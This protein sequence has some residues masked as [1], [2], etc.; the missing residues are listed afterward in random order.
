MAM[1]HGSESNDSR[2]GQQQ[3]DV[4]SPR[5]DV[6]QNPD[7][8]R[9][10]P[11]CSSLVSLIGQDAIRRWN[12]AE[13]EAQYARFSQLLIAQGHPQDE[14]RRVWQL[15]VGDVPLPND[16]SSRPSSATFRGANS[17]PSNVELE[18]V[19]CF[20]GG[21]WVIQFAGKT[22]YSTNMNGLKYLHR[23]L[24]APFF[25]HR[26]EQLYRLIAADAPPQRNVSVDESVVEQSGLRNKRAIPDVMVD[27][28]GHKA[29]LARLENIEI[30]MVEAKRIPDPDLI[31]QLML[32]RIKILAHLKKAFTPVGKR[33]IQEPESVRKAKAID[34]AIRRAK[35]KIKDAQLNEL[36]TH[37]DQTVEVRSL[38]GCSYRPLTTVA[39]RTDPIE[40][41][42]PSKPR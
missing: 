25:S 21:R 33:R 29:M 14:V 31:E 18:N 11:V 28:E 20:E 27:D 4:A 39:W 19:F 12:D 41:A 26:P 22:L 8:L 42:P 38:S 32:E 16:F 6:N 34:I 17:P 3:A 40:F 30:E 5:P 23:L 10:Y 9:L 15:V 1:R 35:E 37:L 36:L 24:S 2:S 13:K 7:F